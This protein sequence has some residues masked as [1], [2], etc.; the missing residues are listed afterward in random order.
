MK[1]LF[2]FAL[3]LFLVLAPV[4][5][6][7]NVPGINN[8]LRMAQR[9]SCTGGT[10]TTVG[11]TRVHTF[12]SSGTLSCVN[13]GSA[14]YLIVGG[15][16]AG[17]GG[18]FTG[19]SS[20]GGG[21]GGFQ[22]GTLFISGSNS[23]LVG[24]GGTAAAA[25]V[26]GS[27]VSSSA[28]GVTSIGGAGGGGCTTTPVTG[29]SGGGGLG[30][31]GTGLGSSGTA[32]QGNN[33]GNG[34]T[35]SPF[36][37]GGGGGAGAVGA[38]AAAGGAGAGGTGSA[39]SISGTPTT[40]AGGGGGGAVGAGVVGAGGLGGGGAGAAGAATGTSATA[41]TGGGGGGGG[42]PPA[43]GNSTGGAGGS[44]VVIVAYS[45]NSTF[46]PNCIAGNDSFTKILLHMDGAN[47]GTSF[48]DVNAGGSA[49]TWT[50]TSP[51]TTSTGQIKFGTA[52]MLGGG[53]WITTPDSTDWTVGSGNFTVDFWLNRNGVAAGENIAGQTSVATSTASWIISVS[54]AGQL[55]ASMQMNPFASI[56]A[57]SA[58]NI[59]GTAWHHVALVR[60]GSTFTLYV[61]GVAGAFPGTS[62]SAVF[63]SSTVLGIGQTGS[64]TAS[65]FTG[66][67]DEFRFSV[68]IARWSANFTPPTVPYCN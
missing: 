60:N 29:A 39:S 32:G 57:Q 31:F 50:V 65:P 40:Y 13:A 45:I 63:D 61:D 33:G 66:Y 7:Q 64:V 43:A 9:L 54:A 37:G 53:G 5:Q 30:G 8:A 10:V 68:G 21:S 48:P 25:A 27:G 59:N 56:L 51:G 23:I 18:C 36:G 47:G 17:G 62:S 19:G 55:S 14:N 4:A 1:K 24:A 38:N 3:A 35:T 52:S 41:N 6:A 26:G 42:N 16:G 2:R 58:T 11:S 67:I 34:L 20:G 44:G 49:H 15:G 28:L 12:T 46:P 22:Q